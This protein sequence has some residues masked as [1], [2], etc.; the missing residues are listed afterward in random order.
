M[1]NM[2]EVFRT[3]CGQSPRRQHQV[4]QRGFHPKVILSHQMLVQKI[5]YIHLNPVKKGL[6]AVAADWP[7]SS[8]AYLNGDNSLPRVDPVAL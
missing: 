7:Y 6:V 1:T 4:W 3:H 8:L 2:S 5:E